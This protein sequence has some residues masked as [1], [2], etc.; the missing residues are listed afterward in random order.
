MQVGEVFGGAPIGDLHLAPGAV[1]VEEDEQIGR[2]VAPVLAVV[3]LDLSR[4]GRDRQAHLADELDRALVEADH[5]PLRV[6]RF[7]VEIEHVLHAGDVIGV[8]LGNAPHVLAPRLELVLGQTPAHRLAR[9][10][11]VRGEPDHRVRQQLQRPAGA[12]RRRARA[13]GRHQQRFLLA[14]ELASRPGA[15]LLAQ[16][17][18]QVAFHEAP[19]G[20]VDR[21]AADADARRDVLVADPRIRG[22]QD[23]RPLEPARRV[24]APAQQR[25]RVRR[26]RIGSTSTR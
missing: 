20:P 4:L 25:R 11:L 3:A 1:R 12:A 13:G 7:G 2:A 23:L 8:D 22:Q 15:R 24:L 6:G 16:R 21:R 26:A 19:L 9:Q 5:R 10:A 17:Q 18:L 14:G